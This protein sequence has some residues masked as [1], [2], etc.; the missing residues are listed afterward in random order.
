MLKQ[1]FEV[2][3]ITMKKINQFYWTLLIII[4][5]SNITF[6]QRVFKEQDPMRI[7]KKSLVHQLNT[8]T[9]IWINGSWKIQSDGT[10]IW[11]KGYWRFEEKS[12]QQKSEIF[13]KKISKNNKT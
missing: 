7:S 1:N 8:P 2:K 11:E 10:R 9:K 6:A 4:L 3:K 5:C 13:R 12:F